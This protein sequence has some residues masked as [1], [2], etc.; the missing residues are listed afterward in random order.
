MRKG[1]NMDKNIII[2]FLLFTYRDNFIEYLQ[3]FLL[4]NNQNKEE[5]I[6]NLAL[7]RQRILNDAPSNKKGIQ[8]KIEPKNI[9]EDLQSLNDH[10]KV[11]Y[12]LYFQDHQLTI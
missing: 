4:K 10:K 12:D 11:D 2:C 3:D 7:G 8:L 9:T 1:N 5:K 6:K